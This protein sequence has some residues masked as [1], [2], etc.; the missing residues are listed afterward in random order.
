[1]RRSDELKSAVLDAMAH[2]VRNPL[3]SAKIAA[4]TLLSEHA[5]GELD[6]R[7]M[8]SIIDEELNPTDRSSS[9][10]ERGMARFIPSEQLRL[11]QY[12]SIS[13]LYCQVQPS[14]PCSAMELRREHPVGQGRTSNPGGGGIRGIARSLESVTCRSRAAVMDSNPTLTDTLDLSKEVSFC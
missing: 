3:N 8:L 12:I 4:T 2:E 10:R 1:V 7:E 13:D 9:K 5:G 11:C 6:R 14:I